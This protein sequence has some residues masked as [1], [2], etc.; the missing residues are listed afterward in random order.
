MEHSL[1][2]NL[3]EAKRGQALT[4]DEYV[5]SP[6]QVLFLGYQAHECHFRLLERSVGMYLPGEEA[7]ASS[8]RILWVTMRAISHT[9]LTPIGTAHLLMLAARR[10][11]H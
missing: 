5:K 1:E 6:C 10:P 3:Y 7:Y 2:F 9:I 8:F 4:L 11:Y